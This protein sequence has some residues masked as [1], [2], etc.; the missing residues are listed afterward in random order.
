MAQLTCAGLV[1]LKLASQYLQ[2]Y[3]EGNLAVQANEIAKVEKQ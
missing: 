3:F 1:A 2:S